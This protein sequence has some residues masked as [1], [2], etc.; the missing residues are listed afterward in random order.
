MRSALAVDFARPAH[1]WV[2]EHD[3]S[4]AGRDAVA[5]AHAS[6]LTLD[7]WQAW[8]V[9]RI[10]AEK[11]GRLTAFEAAIIVGRQNGKGS[12]LEALAL[13][14]LFLEETELILWS[15]HE[16]KTAN[17]AFRRMRTLIQGAPELWPLVNRITTAN[18]DEAIEL[19][20][21]QRLKFV[22]RSKSSGR[23]FTGDKIILDE[24]YDLSADH[25]AAL[26]P[27]LAT[28]PEPQVIYTSSAGMADSVILRGLRDRGRTGGDPSLCWLEWCAMP[29]EIDSSGEAVYD[30]DDRTQWRAANPG[31]DT[32]RITEDFI[33]KER[34]ALTSERFL[35]ERL[36]VWDKPELEQP[37]DFVKWG[38]LVFAGE[39]IG[40]PLFFIDCSPNLRSA[41]IAGAVLI[42]GKPH[43][44]LADHR[45]G[46]DWLP[47]RIRQLRDRYPDARWQY[48]ANGPASA[49]AERF[50]TIGIDVDKPV[51]SSDMCRGCAHLQK[52]V[53]EAGMTHSGDQALT[54]AI[55]SA[56]KRETGDSGL[57]CWG[58][59]KSMGDISPL[60]AAT[61]A[62]WLLE[63]SPSYDVLSSVL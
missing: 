57:W 2:P 5:L 17:E 27:T 21:G 52:L 35:R 37:L 20:S 42:D 47:L 29:Q 59:R 33:A 3:S 28:R 62:L 41:A 56:V 4:E 25:M 53:D 48:E 61:G 30:M 24:A 26:I 45:S 31:I 50:T 8:A 1:C 55:T 32:S 36:G 11:D 39:P 16:F 46:V 22:A 43:V 60:V 34:R 44:S 10:L 19:S 40:T 6:G 38:Q 12:C 51:S 63:T 9:E 49:F 13:N 15:A 58:R 54:A 7:P 23:G 18:G 14:W